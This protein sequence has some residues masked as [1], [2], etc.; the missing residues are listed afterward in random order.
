MKMWLDSYL[1]TS[2]DDN[3]ARQITQIMFLREIKLIKWKIIYSVL[4][5]LIYF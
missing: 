5:S 2:K 3:T 1:E 4:E